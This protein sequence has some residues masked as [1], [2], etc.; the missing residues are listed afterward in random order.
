MDRGGRVDKVAKPTVASLEQRRDEA[1]L[2]ARAGLVLVEPSRA[3]DETVTHR[4]A[5]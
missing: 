2:A 4:R 5:L 1:R 3:S